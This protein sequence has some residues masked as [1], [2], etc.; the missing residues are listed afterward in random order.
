MTRAPTP[1]LIPRAATPQTRASAPDEAGDHEHHPGGGPS[2]RAQGITKRSG[3]RVLSPQ[4]ESR[5]RAGRASCKADPGDDALLDRL[6]AG[7]LP[8]DPL[9]RRPPRSTSSSPLR[10]RSREKGAGRAVADLNEPSPALQGRWT[11]S[12]AICPHAQNGAAAAARSAKSALRRCGEPR[13]G[14]ARTMTDDGH[15]R[16]GD[17]RADARRLRQP[18]ASHRFCRARSARSAC[19]P[20]RRAVGADCGGLRRHGPE[21]LIARRWPARRPRV[22]PGPGAGAEAIR[23]RQGREGR[24]E[25]RGFDATR[26][27]YTENGIYPPPLA[28]STR[29]S[30]TL[31]LNGSWE[32]DLFGRVRAALDAAIGAQRAAEADAAAARVVLAVNVARNYVQLARLLEQREVLQ[33]SLAQ[34]DQVRRSAT[35]LGVPEPP[36]A[37]PRRRR[38]PETRQQIETVESRS[39]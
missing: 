4:R 32:L 11:Q 8:A 23:D 39:C 14:R 26:Q 12:R 27:H 2:A 28:G 1:P 33:R 9:H 10:A 5:G 7:P 25:R 3:G 31:Q 15:R 34:R 36:R 6:D 37:A 19:P 35:R 24:S 17:G 18:P 38:L 30:A 29:D 21:P 13:K 16:D 22:A 20:Q